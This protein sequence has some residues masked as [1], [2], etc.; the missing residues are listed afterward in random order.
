M[1]KYFGVS[2][3]E[4]LCSS[5]VTSS[6]STASPIQSPVMTMPNNPGMAL[7]PEQYMMMMQNYYYQMATHYMQ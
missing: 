1:E 6:S 4:C 2:N 7:T 3:S 5:F